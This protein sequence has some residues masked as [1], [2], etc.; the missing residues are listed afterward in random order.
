MNLFCCFQKKIPI[1]ASDVK[2][3]D[4]K[5]IET[6][7]VLVTDDRHTELS[8]VS[9]YTY[10]DLFRDTEDTDK[11]IIEDILYLMVFKI[12]YKPGFHSV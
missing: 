6:I 2:V 7:N 4:V 3:R 11:K 12:E 9:N 5:D 10:E 8:M 1:K